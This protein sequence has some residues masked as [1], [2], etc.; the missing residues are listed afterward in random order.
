MV[1]VPGEDVQ[2]NLKSHHGAFSGE[3][4]RKKSRIFFLLDSG[5]PGN[6]QR[7]LISDER[8]PAAGFDFP[9][10]GLAYIISLY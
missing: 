8:V 1:K 10:K 2:G 7:V 3:P 4:V 9:G 5:V 6:L